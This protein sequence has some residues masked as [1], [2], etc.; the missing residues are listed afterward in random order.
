MRWQRQALTE[1]KPEESSVRERIE[2]LRAIISETGGV[3]SASRKELKHAFLGT[4]VASSFL[5]PLGSSPHPTG[6]LLSATITVSP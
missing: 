5:T 2:A 6:V 1:R 3:L 4:Y